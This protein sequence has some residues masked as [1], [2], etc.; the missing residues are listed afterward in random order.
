MQP[1]AR[2]PCRP[3]PHPGNPLHLR[4]L[5]FGDLPCSPYPG[6]A[7]PGTLTG[8]L[9]CSR[10]SAG[11]HDPYERLFHPRRVML[12]NS[13]RYSPAVPE[14]RR[15]QMQGVVFVTLNVPG[16]PM[17]DARRSAALQTA[18]LDW[19]EAALDEAERTAAATMVIAFHASPDFASGAESRR[20]GWLLQRI[21]EHALATSRG[22]MAIPSA[23]GGPSAETFCG[24]A[25][26]HP[27]A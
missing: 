23:Q 22:C 12:E 7:V 15:R 16:S 8:G 17:L 14:Y 1:L 21:T 24:R 5:A 19:L 18:A 4:L 26:T 6:G 20:Y 2:P 27:S 9:D 11:A 25:A 13:P 10:A 3:V